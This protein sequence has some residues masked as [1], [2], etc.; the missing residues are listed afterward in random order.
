[1]SIVSIW[2]GVLA[3]NLV[4]PAGSGDDDGEGT[5][6]RAKKPLPNPLQQKPNPIDVSGPPPCSGGEE[7]TVQPS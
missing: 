6:F 4:L 7:L 3:Q 2:G 5:A 1:M